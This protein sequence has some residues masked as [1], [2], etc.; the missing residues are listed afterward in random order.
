MGK[1][2]EAKRTPIKTPIRR[3]DMVKVIAG[4]ERGKVAK[5]LRV[6]RSEGRVLLEGV[7]YVKRHLRPRQASMQGGIVEKEAPLH[8]S[9][10]MLVCSKCMK[11]TRVGRRIEADGKKVRVCK[12]CGEV[13]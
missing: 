10:V 9:N 12:K 1:G 4:K 5:V 8:I 6:Y 11:P 13:I 2:T 3:G 7:N